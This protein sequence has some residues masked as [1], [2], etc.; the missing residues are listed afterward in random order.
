M[1]IVLVLFATVLLRFALVLAV[2]YLMLPVKMS[3]PQCGDKLTLI[4]HPLLRH[5]VPLVEHRWCMGCG[6][7]GV[8]RRARPAPPTPQSRVISRAARS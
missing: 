8:V 2:V 1:V 3:C 6:W 7:N 4:R 5:L